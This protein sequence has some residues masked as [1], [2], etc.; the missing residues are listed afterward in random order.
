MTKGISPFSRPKFKDLTLSYNKGEPTSSFILDLSRLKTLHAE[1]K[2]DGRWG[3][4]IHEEGSPVITL[5]S[6]R[7]QVQTSYVHPTLKSYPTFELHG[8]YIFG[9]NFAKSSDHEGK[10]ILFDMTYCG[11]CLKSLSLTRRRATMLTMLDRFKVDGIELPFVAVQPIADFIEIFDKESI[12]SLA[13]YVSNP[14]LYE[15]VV[16]KDLSDPWGQPWY[17]I[18]PIFEMDYIIM[19]FNQ[20]EAPKY[21]GRMISSIQAG[22]Y[23]GGKIEH[24]CNVSGLNEAERTAMFQRPEDFVGS[25]F[26]A[27]GK[28][29]FKGGALRHPNF[30]RLHPMKQSNECRWSNN[31]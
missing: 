5:Y 2:Y 13:H 24:V 10:V 18:K 23:I 16:I 19:G 20:S 1:P 25:V 4:L 27:S 21:K 31:V 26:T 3:I 6:R 11:E 8:E 22:L 28:S 30:V 9:T 12:E 29:L 15:G 14:D 7:D 17:R